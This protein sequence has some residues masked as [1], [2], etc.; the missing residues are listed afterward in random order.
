M[1]LFLIASLWLEISETIKSK[2]R[3]SHPVF[4]FF[5]L[6]AIGCSLCCMSIWH[7]WVY[8]WNRCHLMVW[9][10]DLNTGPEYKPLVCYQLI[11]GLW[12]SHLVSLHVCNTGIIS[13]NFD[14]F[15]KHMFKLCDI[16]QEHKRAWKCQMKESGTNVAQARS[17]YSP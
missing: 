6:S 17:L 3:K 1:L 5:F 7:I 10:L 8:I 13:L 2:K 11:A 15:K 16:L 9:T 4:F 12:T 14:G